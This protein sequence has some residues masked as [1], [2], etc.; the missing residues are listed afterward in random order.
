MYAL[1][2]EHG[3]RQPRHSHGFLWTQ[4]LHAG[5]DVV[6]GHRGISMERVSVN[7]ANQM[8]QYC[9]THVVTTPLAAPAITV[10]LAPVMPQDVRIFSC[11]RPKVA[12][13]TALLVPCLHNTGPSPL[14]SALTPSVL[15][16]FTAAC[17]SVGFF[18]PDLL[19][20]ASDRL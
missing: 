19:L 20:S 13:L 11:I 2:L 1:S 4:T 8:I 9:S 3:Q 15:T 18:D 12:N 10:A 16:T 7:E 17:T 14:Q 5:F 6:E